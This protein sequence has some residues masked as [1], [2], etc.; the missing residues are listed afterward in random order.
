MAEIN[1]NNIYD[2]M[3]GTVKNSYDGAFMDNLLLI[4]MILIKE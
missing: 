4:N 1:F 2:Q 3:S